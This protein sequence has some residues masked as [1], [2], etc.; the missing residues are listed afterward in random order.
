MHTHPVASLCWAFG[1]GV[2]IAIVVGG[3]GTL[4]VADVDVNSLRG[5]RGN[6]VVDIRVVA[7]GS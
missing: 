6:V 3:L 5:A 2:G 1:G 7:G 4:A